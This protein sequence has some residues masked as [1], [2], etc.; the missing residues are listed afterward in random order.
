MTGYL[1]LSLVRMDEDG[2]KMEVVGE[3][4]RRASEIERSGK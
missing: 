3:R 2:R 4:E 1:L